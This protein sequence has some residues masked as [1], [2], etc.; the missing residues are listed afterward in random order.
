MTGQ[1]VGF[2]SG[3]RKKWTAVLLAA[4]LGCAAVARPASAGLFDDGPSSSPPPKKKPTPSKPVNIPPPPPAPEMPASEPQTPPAKTDSPS[5][6]PPAV[7]ES[8]APAPLSKPPVPGEAAQR[9]AEK[10][11]KEVMGPEIAKART[12]ADRA[13]LAAQMLETAR[14]TSDPAG[15]YVMLKR[16]A[17][18]AA[19]GNDVD[20]AQAAA[21]EA[22]STFDTGAFELLVEPFQVFA[23][24]TP[25]ADNASRLC[26]AAMSAFTDAMAANRYE[27]ARQLGKSAVTFARQ[28]S[29][30]E[31]SEKA[32]AM[33]S[34][35]SACES[36]YNRIVP[37]LATLKR[38]PADPAA[39]AAVGR[40]ECFV[41]GNWS[42][43][44][45]MLAKGNNAALQHA[46][47]EELKSPSDART[48]AVVADAWWAVADTQPAAV[49]TAIRTHAAGLYSQAS[50]G[51]TGLDKLK[52]EQRIAQAKPPAPREVA[53][54]STKPTKPAKTAVAAAVPLDSSGVAQINGPLDV[55]H[56]VPAEMYPKSVVEWTDDRQSAVNDVLR[57]RV[58]GQQGTFGIVVQDMSGLGRGTSVR[59]RSVLIGKMS[60]RLVL[61]FDG[62]A[63]AGLRPGIPCTVTGQIFYPRFEGMELIV[64]MQHC[65]LVQN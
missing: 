46:A 55:I 56:S 47:A 65:S 41:K 54:R 60:F 11:I 13:K 19:Q 51:L 35:V 40:F 16:A 58:S 42:T 7:P 37:S 21:N 52:A 45:P 59:S 4:V 1:R 43:G 61:Q 49:Q 57:Q 53:S 15:K 27:A 8:P 9:A 62:A 28:S 20:T 25:S 5:P 63:A 17:D 39:N 32:G 36:E 3:S 29:N 44:L 30:K 31:M 10:Q 2:E 18:L 23:Q 33:L 34:T 12:P 48:Q 6:P 64:D 24:S 50:D 38:Q 26:D 14:G 22:A